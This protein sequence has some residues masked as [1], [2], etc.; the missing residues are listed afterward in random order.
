MIKDRSAWGGMGD[1]P[2]RVAELFAGVGGFRLGLEGVPSSG[3]KSTFEVVWSNQW[4][5]S[6]KVQWASKIYEERF[7]SDNH[8][9]E[10]IHVALKAV[11]NPDLLVGGFPC[12]DYSVARTK[13]GELGIEGE[14]GKLWNPIKKIIR[15]AEI[16]PKVVF[17][18]NVP[19][20]LRSPSKHR[21]LNFAV[22][23]NDFLSMGYDVEWRVINASEYG[24]PQ[25]RRRVFIIAY[26]RATQ[27]NFY[28][29]GKPN[30]GPTYR[31][32]NSMEKWLLSSERVKNSKWNA[33]PFAEA[34][35][36][37][38]TLPLEKQ[39]FPELETYDWNSKS[40]PFHDAGYVWKDNHGG[41]RWMWTFKPR[42]IKEPV[43]AL[44][45]IMVSKHDSEYEID[46]KTLVTWRYVKGA[47]KE[48]RIRKRDRENVGEKIW[49]IYQEC[50]SSQSQDFWDL[51]AH[52]FEGILGLNSAYRYVEG[53]IAFPDSL[54]RPSRTVVT[55]EIGKSPDRMRHI[56]QTNS[57]VWRRLMPLELERLNMFPDNWTDIEGI[58]PSRRGFLMGNALVVGIIERLREPLA[59]IIHSSD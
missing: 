2:I 19:R 49:N 20:L 10:D 44:R 8:S 13:S 30:F 4:E 15:N 28:R 9:N 53:P 55:Q 40:S 48:F 52:H 1:A 46:E 36:T 5:P 14:K 12:Q 18:E 59:R 54:D 22:I 41:R 31:S 57:G 16:R 51:N 43:M 29:N 27:S 33:G 38:G 47:R 17:L 25:Q 26:R 39:I 3:E 23:C 7:G 58:P 35:P 34:F 45:D 24:M 21:G 11:P 50:M 6:Q 37:K 42:P 32:R 56:I